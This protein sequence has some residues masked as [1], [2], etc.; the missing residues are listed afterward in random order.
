MI[1]GP[2]QLAEELVKMM[3]KYL[4][5]KGDV[6]ERMLHVLYALDEAKTGGSELFRTIN[7]PYE[8]RSTVN[9]MLE[10]YRVN[11]TGSCFNEEIHGTLVYCQTK[12]MLQFYGVWSVLKSV[13]KDLDEVKQLII[14]NDQLARDIKKEKEHE[15]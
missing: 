12:Y 3:D 15:I 6:L 9:Y 11:N 5:D 7:T 8:L 10:H 4:A 1:K 13:R 14:R 2:Q